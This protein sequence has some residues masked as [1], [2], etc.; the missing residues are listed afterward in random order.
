MTGQT[1]FFYFSTPSSSSNRVSTLSCLCPAPLLLSKIP[2]MT[3]DGFVPRSTSLKQN[4][5]IRSICLDGSQNPFAKVRM[6]ESLVKSTTPTTHASVTCWVVWYK[7]GMRM[8]YI[9][10]SILT[11]LLLASH[12]SPL[13]PKAHCVIQ[14]SRTSSPIQNSCGKER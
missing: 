3:R 14:M 12:P 5:N 10:L 13:P 7:L 11:F 8:G 4:P 6:E 9:N 2:I 1:L